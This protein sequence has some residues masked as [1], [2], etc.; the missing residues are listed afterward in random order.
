[1]GT[2]FIFTYLL[3]ISSLKKQYQLASNARINIDKSIAMPI[4]GY[5]T[6]NLPFK[7]LP[8]GEIVKHLGY[9]FTPSGLAPASVVWPVLLGKVE[10]LVCNLSKR[11]FSIPTRMMLFR[12]FVI[13]RL[14]YTSIMI[15][16]RQEDVKTVDKLQWCHD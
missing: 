8:E 4:N 5:N 9:H 16:P 11:S 15:P 2:P 1:M 6:S 7:V 12:S 13:P 3:P 10:H 14:T